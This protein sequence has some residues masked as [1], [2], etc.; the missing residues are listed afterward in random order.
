MDA[1]HAM[2][3]TSMWVAY[4]VGSEVTLHRTVTANHTHRMP[5]AHHRGAKEQD[6]HV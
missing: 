6:A 2:L 1:A 3:H 5:V 4:M